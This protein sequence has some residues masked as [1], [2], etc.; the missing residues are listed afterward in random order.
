VSGGARNRVRE[1]GNC[2]EHMG[3]VDLGQNWHTR[4]YRGERR[5]RGKEG[6][7]A[8][9]RGAGGLHATGMGGRRS[10]E[11]VERERRRAGWGGVGGGGLGGSYR[12]APLNT[13]LPSLPSSSACSSA[14]VA[15][16]RD[17]KSASRAKVK[18]KRVGRRNA[19]KA[20]L[21]ARTAQTER[22]GEGG[23]GPGFAV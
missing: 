1:A 14:Q 2:E 5:G 22:R 19:R 20:Q 13:E 9:W 7:R 3:S 8:K 12:A 15:I 10:R 11:A 17:S 23:G 21:L 6:D 4:R 18:R 16:Q